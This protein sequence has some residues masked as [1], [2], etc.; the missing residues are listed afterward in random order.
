MTYDKYIKPFKWQIKFSFILILV[1]FI[2]NLIHYLFYR[3]AN[4]IFLWTMTSLA[5]LPI[6]VLFVTIIF[7]EILNQ[8]EKQAI[9]EKLNIVIGTYFS[10]MGTNILKELIKCDVNKN[11]LS[12]KLQIK[13]EWTATEYTQAKKDIL[14]YK[15]KI[16]LNADN[17]EKLYKI[18]AEKKG[19]L[20]HM[21]ENPYMVE[22]ESFTDLLMAVFHLLEEFANRDD[23]KNLPHSDIAHLEKDC[24]RV[25]NMMLVEW[26]NYLVSLK[27]FYPYLYSLAVRRNPFKENAT[28]IVYG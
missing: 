15:S 18:I 14:N 12:A 22:H 17:L 26:L 11:N 19:F 9:V 23:F 27:K 16:V 5:F 21:L 25:Y 2:L 20:L 3:D 7:Q 24:E 1:F 10:N 13:Q 8:R 28:V 4:H 6:S